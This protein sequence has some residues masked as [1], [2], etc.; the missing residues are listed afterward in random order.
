[1]N[2]NKFL[3]ELNKLLQTGGQLLD[4]V[5]SIQETKAQRGKDGSTVESVGKAQAPESIPSTAPKQII[6][7]SVP[8]RH[9]PTQIAN[10]I[11][12]II[13]QQG[14]KL[15]D[16][17]KKLSLGDICGKENF[18]KLKIN[19]DHPVFGKIEMNGQQLAMHIGRAVAAELD[20]LQGVQG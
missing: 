4:R 18:E 17:L 15:P 13:T 16:D 2:L 6:E 12:A 8:M 5:K 19:Y 3:G 9:D 20:R 11:V 14:E 7:K 1:M 10:L